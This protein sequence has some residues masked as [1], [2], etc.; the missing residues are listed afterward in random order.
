MAFDDQVGTRTGIS[1]RASSAG[2]RSGAIEHGVLMG[3][4]EQLIGHFQTYACGPG[5]LTNQAIGF[6][7]LGSA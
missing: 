1:S 5:S 3:H 7:V 2:W 4:S 6:S